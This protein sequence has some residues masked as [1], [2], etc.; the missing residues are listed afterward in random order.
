VKCEKLVTI[1]P[2]RFTNLADE[3][4][5]KQ[6]CRRVL[7]DYCGSSYSSPKRL[8]KPIEVYSSNRSVKRWV[9]A[10]RMCAVMIYLDEHRKGTRR[11]QTANYIFLEDPTHFKTYDDEEV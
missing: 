7:C 5:Y 1:P 3:E 8:N 2:P 11:T 6:A 9:V 10:C 4:G